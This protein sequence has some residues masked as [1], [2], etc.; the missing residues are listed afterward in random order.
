MAARAH[1]VRIDARRLEAYSAE[2]PI[3]EIRTRPLT[4]ETPGGLEP[5]ECAAFVIVLDAVNF[6]SGYFPHL[7]KR[8]GMSG[9]RTIEASLR[10]WWNR[11]GPLTAEVLRGADAE[12]C[13]EIFGQSLSTPEVAELMGLFARAW[14]DLAAFGE[15][16]HGGELSHLVRSARGSAAALVRDLCWMPF[17]RDVA[18]YG[19]MPVPFLKRA[20]I[21][22]NDLAVSVTPPF[23]SFWD[24][25]RLTLFADNLVPHV[26]RLDG[27][28]TFAAELE[29]R[30]E[31]G[32]LLV[33]GSPEEVE[34]RACAVHAVEKLSAELAAR[35]ESVTVRELDPWLW[36]RGQHARYKERPRHRSR[37]V[38]Y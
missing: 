11:V 24:L 34:I 20:Q 32:D 16:R 37:T 12:L 38:F 29:A 3:E 30:I 14:R 21:T 9:Y 33:A 36:S 22:V 28:L 31:R 19:G 17:Y 25:D 10:D 7:Q 4:V 23:G 15:D 26:L 8:A 35:G 2:L 1:H 5:H 13:A 6:G 18:E 27:V